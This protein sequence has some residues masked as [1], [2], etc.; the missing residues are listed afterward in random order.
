MSLT[1]LLCEICKDFA[2]KKLRS[3]SYSNYA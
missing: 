2:E 1:N 3:Y